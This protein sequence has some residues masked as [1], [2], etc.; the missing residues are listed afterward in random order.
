M[1][2]HIPVALQWKGQCGRC[3]TSSFNFEACS[4]DAAGLVG[5]M[6]DILFTPRTRIV[7]AKEY[8]LGTVAPPHYG[9][10][11]ARLARP[12]FPGLRRQLL[13][14]PTHHDQQ[15]VQRMNAVRTEPGARPE[16]WRIAKFGLVEHRFGKAPTGFTGA[17]TDC[18]KGLCES[19]I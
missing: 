5:S 8:A 7:V 9:R 3:M 14:Q 13:G 2:G 19:A 17:R 4:C 12:G 16:W 18:G 15:R 11:D 1:L 10:K 6:E